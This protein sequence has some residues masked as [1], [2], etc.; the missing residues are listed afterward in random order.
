MTK[1]TT[2][3]VQSE[4]VASPILVAV[5][6]TKASRSA[7]FVLLMAL[8]AYQF[9]TTYGFPSANTQ[10][11]VSLASFA[12][13]LRPI[14]GYWNDVRPVGRHRRKN[15]MS[16]GNVLYLAAI[17]LLLVLP[18]PYAGAGYLV[19]LVAFVTYGLGE[20]F[21]DV[22]T[23]SLLLDVATTSTEKSRVQGYAR[24][25][26]V[27]GSLGTYALATGTIGA[28]A[29]YPVL[30]GVIAA[31]ILIGTYLTLRIQETPLT[32]AQAL[33]LVSREQTTIPASYKVTLWIA[34][35]TFSLTPL[36]EGLVNVQLEPWLIARYGALPE[37][38]YAVELAGAAIGVAALLAIVLL[39]RRKPWNVSILIIPAGL[40]AAL[41]YAGLPWLAPDLIGYAIWNSAKIAAGAFAVLGME[42]ALMDVVKGA[43]K[44]ATFQFFVVFLMAGSFGGQMLGSFLGEAMVFEGLLVIAGCIVAGAVVLYAVVL[45]PR[46]KEEV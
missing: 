33:D 44:G 34:C 3:K 21:I 6:V 13:L 27:A 23:D 20:A 8:V 16:L 19:V 37:I 32:R 29:P 15:F 24:L 11:L 38:F 2:I 30:L 43:R 12:G 10:F 17:S 1:Q 25:G 31:A 18:N 28:G 22:G 14:L 35:I 42:R 4:R 5:T 46:L 26:A 41:F 40:V 45:A 36:A 39:Q 9:Q 7:F